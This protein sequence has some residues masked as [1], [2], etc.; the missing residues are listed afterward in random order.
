MRM[1]NKKVLIKRECDNFYIDTNFIFRNDKY[2]CLIENKYYRH[3]LQ[4]QLKYWILTVGSSLLHPPA[5]ST[6]T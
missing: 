4:N 5:K 2:S 1:V 6:L 3:N